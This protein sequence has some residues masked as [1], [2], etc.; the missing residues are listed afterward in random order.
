MLRKGVI[1]PAQADWYSIFVFVP[2]PTGFWQFCIDCSRRNKFMIQ[3]KYPIQ[4]MD[5]Y[6][7]YLGETAW[8]SW[9]KENLGYSQVLIAQEDSDENTFSCQSGTY[10]SGRMPLG[11]TSALALFQRTLDILLKGFNWQTCLIYLN[12]MILFSKSFNAHLRDVSMLP[13]TLC[14]ASASFNLRKCRFF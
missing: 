2:Q 10:N 11:S 1:D 9:L 13:P 7:D 12:D 6:V 14:K 5:D 8:L 4:K 3:E